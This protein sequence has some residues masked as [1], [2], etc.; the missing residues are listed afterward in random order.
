MTFSML[1]Q[2]PITTAE[3]NLFE[4]NNND[5]NGA[6]YLQQYLHHTPD[7]SSDESISKTNP[8]H[9]RHTCS[10][11][12]AKYISVT[13]RKSERAKLKATD[14]IECRDFYKITGALPL[15]P[16][17]Y[18]PLPINDA[19]NHED[20]KDSEELLKARKQHVSRHRYKFIPEDEP[21]GFWDLNYSPSKA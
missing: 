16:S 7:L 11:K 20:L 10:S 4:N 21:S 8:P 9:M 6:K 14:C 12:P 5:N 1:L 19:K 18:S 17:I 3:Q 2:E 13:R 15:P